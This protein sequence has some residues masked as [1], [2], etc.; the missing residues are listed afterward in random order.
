MCLIFGLSVMYD[1]FVVV[2]DFFCVCCMLCVMLMLMILM[3]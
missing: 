3:M 1:V 2:V